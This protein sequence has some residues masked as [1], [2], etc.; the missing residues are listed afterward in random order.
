MET[1]MALAKIE[2]DDIENAAI[3]PVT[4]YFVR[5]DILI[6]AFSDGR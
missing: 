6:E 2:N 5:I 1:K 3:T 4:S